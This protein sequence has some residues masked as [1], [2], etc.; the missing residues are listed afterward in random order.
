[1]DVTYIGSGSG[2]S[3][4]E[5]YDG[6]PYSTPAP[7]PPHHRHHHHHMAPP[8]MHG[9][10]KTPVIRDE[11][12]EPETGEMT[13]EQHRRLCEMCQELYPADTTIHSLIIAF[14]LAIILVLLNRLVK[15]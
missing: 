9:D 15:K 8:M 1:M 13:L 6:R 11:D 5:D 14:L 2:Y 7:A 3:R 10:S 12:L 4:Y